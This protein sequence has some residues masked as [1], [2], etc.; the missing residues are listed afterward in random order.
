LLSQTSYCFCFALWR[1]NLVFCRHNLIVFVSRSAGTKETKTKGKR[2]VQFKE[3]RVRFLP[4]IPSDLLRE[5]QPDSE[6]H[7]P[8]IS[9][10]PWNLNEPQYK[11][12][13]TKKQ[14]KQEREAAE[15]QPTQEQEI[16]RPLLAQEEQGI[17]KKQ[18]AQGL[19]K[20]QAIGWRRYGRCPECL[21]NLAKD[22]WYL[23]CAKCI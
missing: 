14:P 1:H 8:K 21:S 23:V 3:E 17:A 10:A 22:P 13:F 5:Y 15:K 11:A 9:S 2:A 20:K 12:G 4:P 16:A 19:S 7:S 18:Q 6:V